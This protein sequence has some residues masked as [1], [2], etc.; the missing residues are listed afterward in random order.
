MVPAFAV[1]L[2]NLCVPT[3]SIVSRIDTVPFIASRAGG[4]LAITG[5]LQEQAKMVLEA[6]EDNFQVAVT[7]TMEDWVLISGVRRSNG[8]AQPERPDD[9]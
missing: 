3:T 7:D 2:L 8:A 4:K 1:R 9:R 5:I 6:Y